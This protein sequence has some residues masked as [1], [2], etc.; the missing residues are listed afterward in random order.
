MSLNVTIPT[1]F[2]YNGNEFAFDVRDADDAEKFEKALSSL[3]IDEAAI[4]KTGKLSDL[5]RS[6]CDMMKKF[7]D[8]C[9]GDGAGAKVCTE[10]SNVSV[11]YSAYA[12]FLDY[13]R[14]QQEDIVRAKNVFS[15]YSN[16]KQ[17]READRKN[18]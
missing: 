9:L 14:K 1:V 16:R 18:K 2:A 4:P 7:F 13:V 8:N 17:R 12:A 11:C 6:H 5:Y 3:Q 15:K 10:K